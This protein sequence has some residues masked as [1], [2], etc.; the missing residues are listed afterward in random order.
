MYHYTLE[1]E[2]MSDIIVDRFKHEMKKAV[3]KSFE[4]LEDGDLFEAEKTFL[5]SSTEIMRGVFAET[6]IGT[7]QTLFNKRDPNAK[8][9]SFEKRKILTTF[10]DIQFARRRYKTS[11]NS[12]SY[13]LDEEIDLP[14]R[15]KISPFLKQMIASN[16]SEESYRAVI[17]T[18]EPYVDKKI[19]PQSVKN[20]IE[21]VGKIIEQDLNTK[22]A[23]FWDDCEAEGDIKADS[24]NVEADGVF[25][26]MQRSKEEKANDAPRKQ[27]VKVSKAYRGKD[28]NGCQDTVVYASISNIDTFWYNTMTKIASKYDYKSI[29]GGIL[30]TDGDMKYKNGIDYLPPNFSNKLDTWHIY[31]NIKTCIEDKEYRSDLIKVIKEYGDITNIITSLNT[32]INN[33]TES[34]TSENMKKLLTYLENNK[35]IIN[36][37]PNSLGTMESTNGHVVGSR[38]KRFGGGWSK[39]GANHLLS[40]SIVKTNGDKLP[41]I[42]RKTKV[43]GDIQEFKPKNLGF[44]NKEVPYD[45]NLKYKIPNGRISNQKFMV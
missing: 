7:D 41:K 43:Y 6:L 13:L 25:I 3:L 1:I 37:S 17:R 36:T 31:K 38:Y 42:T 18:L 33:E 40:I 4:C 22:S 2:E 15:D 19:S 30:G 24:L 32:K 28:D 44:K 11:D 21:E 8:V 5:T 27:E 10:G 39:N 12:Y 29:K 20:S 9:K 35:D 26:A 14:S 23:N 45:P 16:A 34:K